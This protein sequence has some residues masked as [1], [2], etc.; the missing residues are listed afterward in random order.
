MA[1]RVL[2]PP[3]Q[4]VLDRG[5]LDSGFSCVLQMP[6]GA[7]KTWLAEQAI[8]RTLERGG[9]AIYL[10]PLRALADELTARWARDLPAAV[11][12]FTGDYGGSGKPY[13]TSFSAARLLVMTP[14]RL[15]ACTR[16]WRSHWDWITELELVVADEFHLLGDAHRGSRLEGA[17]S[18]LRRLN[19]FVRFLGLSATL[20]N[21]EEL[22]CWLG[23]IDYGTTWRPV[24]LEWRIVR[25]RRADEKPA[26]LLQEVL[27]NRETGGR[28]LVFVQSRR[29]AESL[30]GHLQEAGLRVSHHHSG[31][32]HRARRNAEHDFR[33]GRTDV[34]VAT[35]TLEMGLNLP[36][37]QVVLYDLQ[38]FDG[39]DFHP[40]PAN[41]VWQ[42]A[43]RAGRPGLD[44]AGEAVLLAPS[45]D[46]D[47]DRYPEG[48]FEPI[49][50]AL[51]TPR[52]L[53]EQ[54]VAEVA[55]GLA[56]TPGQLRR[57]F[58]CS[59]AAQQ[60]S[61]PDVD[62]VIRE[63]CDAGMVREAPPVEG[64]GRT[65]QFRVTPLG[66]T[67]VRHLL[68][69]ATV[70][71]FR[72]VLDGDHSLSLLDLLLVAA[73]SPDCEPVLPVDFEELDE[74]AG[75]LEREH[76]RLLARPLP[77]LTELLGV[78]GKR[79]LAVLKM[80]LVARAWTRS[81]DAEEVARS[82]NCYAF[83]VERLRD[84]VERLLMAMEEVE[85]ILSLDPA[86]GGEDVTTR[87]RLKALRDMVCAGLDEEA[88]TLTLVRGIGAKRARLLKNAG[89][90]DIEELAQATTET[91]A[92][93]PGLSRWRAEQWIGAATELLTTRSALS[94][95]D[96]GPAACVVV[97]G[98]P[99]DVDPY[100]LR[101][102]HG[103]S[104]T[105][106]EAGCF[107]VTG[108]TDPH[109]VQLVNGNLRCDCGDAA[110]GHRCKHVLA[111]ELK[112]GDREL[113]RLVRQLEAGGMD[114]GLDLMSLWL[115]EHGRRT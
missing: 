45:W 80:A 47:V 86:D 46:R 98:W 97:S 73:S 69:P 54:I 70:L 109:V 33:E 95:R 57:V 100:R 37:R 26:L 87:E 114:G 24:P 59:L 11:G 110:L 56:R 113:W 68:S 20:G 43:G 85:R 30:C 53:A 72:T 28:S 71:M 66:R 50:S 104:V 40:L 108:G 78:S 8:A 51:A 75:C 99:L 41:S 90:S 14:E 1:D 105:A 79:L 83:E 2:T 15:D 32:S 94:F 19:P 5:L 48:A 25:Y 34:L 91:L 77:E 74:L 115:G 29:R 61:L 21:R 81:G 7:G 82:H 107:R 106:P 36:A 9:R 89:I 16:N 13:P 58:H 103:L 4:Q 84:S 112:R 102:A 64:S 101:R 12:V 42:R 35:S 31:L 10:T 27:R 23:G 38:A 63:M 55:S 6:T 92:A 62:R 49:R 111:I 76:T 44:S 22:A 17:L 88:V 67:T 96:S 93:L 60:D 39:A 3:Q 65:L 52:L 18:R